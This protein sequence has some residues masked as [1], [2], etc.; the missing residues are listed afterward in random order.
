MEPTPPVPDEPAKPAPSIIHPHNKGHKED[1][2][3]APKATAGDLDGLKASAL[4]ELR[5][6]V[7]KLKLPAKERFDTLLLIIRST[8]DQSL[9]GQA[10]DAAKDIEDDT[11]RA[12]ALLDVIKEIDYFSSKR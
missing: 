9:L 8:D 1:T 4:E 5:P 3:P 2:K 11:Q 6:L 7:G 12:E 10:H